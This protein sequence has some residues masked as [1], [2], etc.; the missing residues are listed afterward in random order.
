MVRLPTVTIA[1]PSLPALPVEEPYPCH[2]GGEHSE[3][4]LPV[5]PEEG[6]KCSQLRPRDHT[7]EGCYMGERAGGEGRGLIMLSDQL[8]SK[9][10]H[11][12][13]VIYSKI[14]LAQQNSH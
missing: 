8:E 6:H 10:A 4:L 13:R 1:F 11:S 12:V 5:A 7:L 9:V 3:L 14:K 2:D